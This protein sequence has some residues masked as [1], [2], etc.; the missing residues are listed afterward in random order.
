MSPHR[1]PSRRAV[2]L[3]G[4]TVDVLV[5]FAVALQL[6]ERSFVQLSPLHRRVQRVQPPPRLVDVYA[7][8]FGPRQEHVIVESL[9]GA[10]CEKMRDRYVYIYIDPT[11][12]QNSSS[13]LI[14]KKKKAF[15]WVIVHKLLLSSTTQ[16]RS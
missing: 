9:C 15:V 6:V 13:E 7:R 3:E 10:T 12:L 5:V 2:V 4:G 16:K 11:A 1:V 8:V 14:Q